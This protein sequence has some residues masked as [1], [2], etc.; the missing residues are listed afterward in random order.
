MTLKSH[1]DQELIAQQAVR[2]VRD[3]LFRKAVDAKKAEIRERASRSLL[4]R[5]FPWRIKIV[6][7]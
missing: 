7:R 6:R 4:A 2:E 1:H 3:E 5:L